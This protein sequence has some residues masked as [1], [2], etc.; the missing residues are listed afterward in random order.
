MAG[1]VTLVRVAV[2]LAG[3]AIPLE[4]TVEVVFGNEPALPTVTS[5]VMVQVPR[6]ASAPPWSEMPASP[7]ALFAVLPALRRAPPQPLAALSGEATVIPAGNESVKT[8]LV[9]AA[10]TLLVSTKDS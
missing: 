9:R 4:V 7:A 3:P 5:T 1:F 10:L 2:L 8:M 6:A